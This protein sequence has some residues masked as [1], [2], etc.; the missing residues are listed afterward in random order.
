[1]RQKTHFFVS[2]TYAVNTNLNQLISTIRINRAT[3]KQGVN[4]PDF[5][6]VFKCPTT[7]RS[8]EY[9]LSVTRK[10]Y[11]RFRFFIV[12]PSQFQNISDQASSNGLGITHIQIVPHKNRLS[13]ER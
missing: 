5:H 9:L 7:C 10:E 2:T 4:R 1:M 11:Y 6:L 13:I 8:K 3:N 12:H